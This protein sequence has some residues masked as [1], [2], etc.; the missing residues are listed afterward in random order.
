[1]AGPAARVKPTPPVP[2]S[3]KCLGADKLTGFYMG[4][5]G[6]IWGRDFLS[7][8]AVG[9]DG[10]LHLVWVRQRFS[11]NLWCRLNYG[12]SLSDTNFQRLLGTKYP[13]V[14]AEKLL[15]HRKLHR[16]SFPR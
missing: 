16:A 1:M 9:A 7:R 14:S 8:D 13:S 6:Y 15:P 12:P 11:F 2:S 3:P 5:D 4:P 10:R